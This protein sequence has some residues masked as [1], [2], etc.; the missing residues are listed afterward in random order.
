MVVRD[1]DLTSC[2]LNDL[3]VTLV[4]LGTLI[5]LYLRYT[6][7]P[8]AS[9]ELMSGAS[10]LGILSTFSLGKLFR[11]VLLSQGVVD[12]LR[13]VSTTVLLVLE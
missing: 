12:E 5:C 9:G 11:R 4:E 8:L 2:R 3:I 1:I 10:F 13:L 7:D 6:S